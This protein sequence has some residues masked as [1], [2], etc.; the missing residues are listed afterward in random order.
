[1][2]RVEKLPIAKP[3]SKGTGSRLGPKSRYFG[4]GGGSLY[5]STLLLVKLLNGP[6]PWGYS[7]KQVFVV[8][9]KGAIKIG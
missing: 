1:M 4:Q 7:G 2:R 6:G 3:S 9:S 5:N 8:V